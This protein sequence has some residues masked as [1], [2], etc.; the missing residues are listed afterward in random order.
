MIKVLLALSSRD[1][2]D[3][4][5]IVAEIMDRNL[6][7]PARRIWPERITTLC[8]ADILAKILVETSRSVGLSAIYREL[9]SFDG[10][11]L[12]FESGEWNGASFGSLAYRFDDGIPIG[13]QGPRPMCSSSCP[14]TTRAHWARRS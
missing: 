9:L 1:H 5:N 10:V 14:R 12:Y 11:E 3:E 8:P 7:H 6:H 13:F 4:L 2:N